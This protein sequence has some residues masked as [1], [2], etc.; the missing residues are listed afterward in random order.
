MN[1]IKLTKTK[2]RRARE[3]V[4]TQDGKLRELKLKR[5]EINN[6]LDSNAIKLKK[7]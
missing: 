7:I 1:M 2:L 3:D 5:N 6:L 4:I